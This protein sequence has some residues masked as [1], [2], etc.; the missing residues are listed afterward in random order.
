MQDAE[1][2]WFVQHSYHT[3]RS[4]HCTWLVI[5]LAVSPSSMIAGRIHSNDLN[6]QYLQHAEWLQAD[7]MLEATQQAQLVTGTV[8]CPEP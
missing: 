3:I 6:P 7:A 2:A 1:R 4:V 8:R 5:S